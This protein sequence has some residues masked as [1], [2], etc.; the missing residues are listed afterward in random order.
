MPSAFINLL[1]FLRSKFSIGV[2]LNPPVLGPCM[3]N[4]FIDFLK[5]PGFSH[6]NNHLARPSAFFALPR[7]KSAALRAASALRAAGRRAKKKPLR[8]RQF[9]RGDDGT[10]SWESV[11]G[12]FIGGR[13]KK[14][15]PLRGR[16]L[17]GIY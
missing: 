3:D 11:V 1:N 16:A 14:E 13:Q 6:P 4:S 5:K 2:H 12:Q 8:G 10:A 9:T 15:E 17:L 7:E